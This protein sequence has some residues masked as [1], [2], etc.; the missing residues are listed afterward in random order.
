MTDESGLVECPACGHMNIAGEDECEQCSSALSDLSRPRAHSPIERSIH[1]IRVRALNP[2]IA[3]TVPPHA[4]IAQ[5]LRLLVE[6]SVGCLVVVDDDGKPVGI[7]SER[8]ALLRLNVDYAAHLQ[9][10]VSDFMT[11]RVETL[12]G[13]AVDAGHGR[14]LP[15]LVR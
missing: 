7:F 4:T 14:T 6:H 12:A 1:K 3:L 11:P 10:P 13:T 15:E 8:D 5:V 2:R 9:R